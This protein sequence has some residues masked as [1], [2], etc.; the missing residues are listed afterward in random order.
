[1]KLEDAYPALVARA[2]AVERTEE[3]VDK[4]RDRRE[5][6][7]NRACTPAQRDAARSAIKSSIRRIVRRK[8]RRC[9]ILI[10]ISDGHIGSAPRVGVEIRHSGLSAWRQ[11]DL[12]QGRDAVEWEVVKLCNLLNFALVGANA[13]EEP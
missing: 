4:L 9:S 5:K 12:S 10:S 6:I 1:M 8:V 11:I 13:P 2:N 7:V 3:L